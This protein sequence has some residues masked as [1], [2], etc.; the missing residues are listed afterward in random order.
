MR[1][2]FSET[3]RKGK[4]SSELGVC[5]YLLFPYG[6]K[7]I[8]VLLLGAGELAINGERCI[9]DEELYETLLKNFRSLALKSLI[10][11]KEE[12]PPTLENDLKKHLDG[13]ELC[14]LH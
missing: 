12:I 3:V 2:K 11:L 8:Q 7:S 13:G 6:S 1:G 9:P 10:F 14:I 4:L 5:S